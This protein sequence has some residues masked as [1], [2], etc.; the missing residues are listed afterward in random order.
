MDVSEEATTLK[1]VCPVSS[2][3]EVWLVA[4]AEVS[5]MNKTLYVLALHF[6]FTL[7]VT[8]ELR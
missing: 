8:G 5:Q 7:T 1:T 3:T 2:I 6:T 4:V